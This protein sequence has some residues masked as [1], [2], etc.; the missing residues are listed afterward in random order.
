MLRSVQTYAF[1]QRML[2]PNRQSDYVLPDD[3]K[4]LAPYVLGH[5][6]I[7]AGRRSPKAIILRLL[8]AI[9]VP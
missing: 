1:I 4:F 7:A 5:R 2:N 6:I 8:D 9:A 3:V